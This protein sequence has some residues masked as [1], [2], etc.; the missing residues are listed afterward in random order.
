MHSFG[1]S[2][3]MYDFEIYQGMHALIQ[4]VTVDVAVDHSNHSNDWR[5]PQPGNARG[6]GTTT[7]VHKPSG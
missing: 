6:Q 7:N 4:L 1:S 3:W 2:R 5:M